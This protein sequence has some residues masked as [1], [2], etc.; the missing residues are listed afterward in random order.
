MQGG[1]AGNKSVAR[2]PP[3]GT[4]HTRLEREAIPRPLRAAR[5]GPKGGFGGG[6]ATAGSAAAHHSPQQQKSVAGDQ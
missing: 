6:D 2:A 1:I 4:A 3:T 5:Q